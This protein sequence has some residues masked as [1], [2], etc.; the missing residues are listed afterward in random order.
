MIFKHIVIQNKSQESGLYVK[1]PHSCCRNASKFPFEAY[2]T[3]L[4]LSTTT[5]DGLSAYR[6]C[7]NKHVKEYNSVNGMYM[8][9]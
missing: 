4:K 3:L 7:N 6:R 5:I 8:F 9:L 1:L 2:K